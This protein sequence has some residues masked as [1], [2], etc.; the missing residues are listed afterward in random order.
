MSHRRTGAILLHEVRLLSRDPLPIMILV[1]FPLLLIAFLK[2]MFAL[3]LTTHGHPGANGAEQVVPGEAVINGFYIVGMTSFAFFVEHGWKTWD[4]LRASNATSSE[5]IVGKALPFCFISIV[6][7][8]VIFAIGVPLFQLHSHGPLAA[9][10]PL[11]AAFA[12]CLVTLGVMVTSLCRTIQQVSAL[13]FGGLVLFGALG[14]ALVPLEVL[15]GWAR[16]V[17]PVTPTY[18]VMRGFGSVILNGRSLPAIVLPCLVLTGMSLA[19]V[20]VSLRRFRFADAKV[21]F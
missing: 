17:A 6:Q 7:F 11:V 15:P 8:L 19:F 3:A 5:I 16:S 14:G 18:W 9:L 4:R 13:A 10:I 12:L 2:P 20:A 1:V 21:S